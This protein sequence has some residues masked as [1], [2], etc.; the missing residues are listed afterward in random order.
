MSVSYTTGVPTGVVPR[1]YTYASGI[2]ASTTSVS[3]VSAGTGGII[4]VLGYGRFYIS[5]AIQS[6]GSVATSATFGVN[7][8]LTP[9]I[10]AVGGSLAGTTSIMSVIVAIGTGQSQT[11][12]QVVDSS[13][14]GQVTYILAFSTS[15]GT[16][17]ITG[18]G[19]SI[20]IEE[21]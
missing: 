6:S 4:N 20:Y 13:Q 18:F 10:P 11:S 7:R 8:S 3:L 12:M 19:T 16:L 9:T 2:G 5:V 14:T 15:S 17:T 1:N 21:I